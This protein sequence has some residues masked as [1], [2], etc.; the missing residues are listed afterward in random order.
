MKFIFMI[1]AGLLTT[2]FAAP[3]EAFKTIQSDFIQNVT[4]EQNKTIRY[5]GKFYATKEKKALWIYEKPVAKKIYFNDTKVVIIEPELEQAIITTLENTPNIAQLIREAK[6]VAP[7]RYV[8]TFMDTIYTIRASQNHLEAVRYKD[9]LDNTVEI[10]FS[11]Q[12]TNLFLDEPL[13][14]A[15]I[16]LGYDLIRQ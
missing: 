6:E 10:L 9:K 4:N 16:P 13:F 5:E 12:S 14:T 3:L 15:D 8:T 7:N 2:L 1:L 11:N